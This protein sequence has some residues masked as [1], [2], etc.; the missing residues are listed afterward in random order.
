MLKMDSTQEKKTN[1]DVTYTLIKEELMQYAKDI[2]LEQV[3]KMSTDEL[4]IKCYNTIKDAAYNME[5]G[6]IKACISNVLD[7]LDFEYA[8]F[9]ENFS[10]TLK[11]YNRGMLTLDEVLEELLKVTE[12]NYNLR[13]YL[14][15]QIL[16]LKVLSE[17][18]LQKP[19]SQ[20][21]ID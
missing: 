7:D 1:Y 14:L 13:T 6:L 12:Y 4:F 5:L 11:K 16:D 9:K 2:S 15:H 3:L 19:T 21:H 18:I 8:Y 10:N 20:N 17:R